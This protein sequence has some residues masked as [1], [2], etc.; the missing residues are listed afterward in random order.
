MLVCWLPLA[1]HKHTVTPPPPKHTC[2][3]T[4]PVYHICVHPRRHQLADA[5]IEEQL[6]V[7]TAFREQGSKLQT[8]YEKKQ[9][10]EYEISQ[11]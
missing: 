1:V 6:E 3:H 8:M 4:H 7:Q 11:R 10:T 9:R 5:A 2:S